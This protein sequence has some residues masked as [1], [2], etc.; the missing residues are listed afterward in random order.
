MLSIWRGKELFFLL[1]TVPD[2]L[3]LPLF[4]WH[5][6]ELQEE[7]A[8]GKG[9]WLIIFMVDLKSDYVCVNSVD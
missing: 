2:L 8:G 3:L 7:G 1:S 9:Y 5:D 4:A 6:I